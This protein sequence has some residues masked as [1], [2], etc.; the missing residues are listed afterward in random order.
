MSQSELDSF[1]RVLHDARVVLMLDE[2]TVHLRPQD[3]INDVHAAIGAPSLQDMPPQVVDEHAKLRAIVDTHER[4][5]EGAIVRTARFRKRFWSSVALGSGVQMLGLSY[6]TFVQYDWDVMEPACFFVTAGTS[7]F[8]YLYLLL[9]RREHSLQAVDENL[10]P[11][12]LDQ[13]LQVAGV[14]AAK[15]A[16]D[17]QRLNEL[18]MAH[19]KK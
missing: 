18:E 4:K 2:N 16:Q 19:R 5:S 13:A 10:L 3:A 14:D 7:I 8:F 15:W 1:L 6:L 11:Q 12:H 17:A 9:F